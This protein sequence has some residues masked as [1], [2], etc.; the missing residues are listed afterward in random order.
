L[1]LAAGLYLV[2]LWPLIRLISRFE[3]KI[4]S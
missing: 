3:R 4:Y 2:L 1:V